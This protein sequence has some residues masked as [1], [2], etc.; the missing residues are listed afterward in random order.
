MHL[1]LPE[2]T[3]LHDN[4]LDMIGDIEGL[5]VLTTFA[6]VHIEDMQQKSG[7]NQT[8]DPLKNFL[9]SIFAN[10]GVSNNLF[11][12][13]GNLAL[14]KS[15]SNDEA[16]MFMLFVDKIENFLNYELKKRFETDEIGLI[17]NFPRITIYN[18]KDMAD[19]FKGQAMYG[20]S[21]RLPAIATGQTQSSLMAAIE[22]ENNVMGMADIMKPLQSS[23]TQ[24]PKAANNNNNNGSN[25]EANPEGR[26]ELPDDQKSDKTLK[27]LASIG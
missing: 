11:A 8:N 16:I 19:L 3:Q 2:I 10:A 5:D 26:P 18:F 14:D 12:T 6:N 1:D 13:D 22:Y 9:N 20:Y 4:A 7:F 21:K 23:A 15:I 25:G 24:S 17:C 27:N